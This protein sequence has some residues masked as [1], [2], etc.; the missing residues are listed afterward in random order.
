MSQERPPD[1]PESPL[2]RKVMPNVIPERALESS[3]SAQPPR[4]PSPNRSVAETGGKDKK[5]EKRAKKERKGRRFSGKGVAFL[6]AILL[7]A[8]CV[9]YLDYKKNENALEEAAA[10][11]INF[12]NKQMVA[13]AECLPSNIVLLPGVDIRE[14]PSIVMPGKLPLLT[15]DN[16]HSEVPEGSEVVIHASSVYT[17]A[18]TKNTWLGFMPEDD[19]A[20]AE[21][22]K[23]TDA[24]IQD[25]IQQRLWVNYTSLQSQK[26]SAG[27]PYFTVLP[28]E[29]TEANTP[30][31]KCTV[32]QNGQVLIG[33]TAVS[34]SLTFSQGAFQQ[35]TQWQKAIPK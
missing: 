6:G 8:G 23:N 1:N 28:L 20:T 33:K 7:A 9:G 34:T 27:K 22:L 32:S 11:E 10:E 15:H 2:L 16:V 25:V 18:E 35:A 26:D 3:Q 17:D 12:T 19:P 4:P 30:N 14:N 31:E 21:L 29:G 13:G 5:R 24:S